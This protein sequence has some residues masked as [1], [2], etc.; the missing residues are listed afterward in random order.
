VGV[1]VHMFTIAMVPAGTTMPWLR[2]TSAVARRAQL[3][4]G[5]GGWAHNVSFTT[6]CRYGMRAMSVSLGQ[7]PAPTVA[8]ASTHT[9]AYT[10]RWR[11]SSAMHHSVRS[12]M[13]AQRGCGRADSRVVGETACERWRAYAMAAGP[14]Q[15]CER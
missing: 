1:M 4:S 6:G 13:Q 15:A 5:L 14:G 3:S 7:P 12:V 2:G 8:S 10:A 9:L 11:T